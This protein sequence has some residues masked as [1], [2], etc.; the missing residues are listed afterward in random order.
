MLAEDTY[1]NPGEDPVPETERTSAA[2]DE[3]R[4]VAALSRRI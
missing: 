3:D 2:P 4:A 1:V